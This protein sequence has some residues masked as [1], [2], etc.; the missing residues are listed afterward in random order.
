M[1]NGNT[2][3]DTYGPN[4]QEYTDQC[5]TNPRL[6]ALCYGVGISKGLKTAWLDCPVFLF[7]LNMLI[8]L[9]GQGRYHQDAEVPSADP[10]GYRDTLLEPCAG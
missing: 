3:C 9:V 1:A 6:N 10:G 8:S 7:R 4:N 2:N 5:E